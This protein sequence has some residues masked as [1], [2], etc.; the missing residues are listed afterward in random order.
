MIFKAKKSY[1]FTPDIQDN[2]TLPESQRLK[3]RIVR[4]DAETQGELS[5]MEIS[6]DFTKKEVSEV[7]DGKRKKDEE[8]RKASLTFIRKQDTGR[9]L[10]ECVSEI[11]N[12]PVEEE[13]AEG[14]ISVKKIT[15]GTELACSTAFGLGR[16]IELICAE[17]LKDE[18]K[19]DTEKNSESASSST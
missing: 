2:L 16:L 17:C 7:K 13:D 1:W 8:P 5:A 3:V 4:P 11:V 10:R 6:R 15:T 18:L 14:K 19:D 12:C 9:I